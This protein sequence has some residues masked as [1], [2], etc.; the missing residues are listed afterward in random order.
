MLFLGELSLG[1]EPG[2]ALAVRKFVTTIALSRF[3]AFAAFLS[4][5][6]GQAH[7]VE[8]L[9]AGGANIDFNFHR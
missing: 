6:I 4:G 9:H 8:V 1:R 7:N 3:E 2:D 5:V